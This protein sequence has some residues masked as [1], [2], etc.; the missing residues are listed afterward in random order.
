MRIARSALLALTGA[1]VWISL[2]TVAVVD[3]STTR[4]GALPPVWLLI[5]LTTAGAGAGAMWR[6]PMSTLAPLALTALLWLPWLPFPVP[7]AFLIWSGPAEWLLWTV[8]IGGVAAAL[9]SPRLPSPVSSW[10]MQ[11]RRAVVLTIVLGTLAALAAARHLE[12]RI[13]AGDEPHYLIITQSVLLDGDLQIENNH[14]RGDYQPYS[15]DLLRPDFLRRGVNGQIYS[16]HAPGLPVL[17]APAFAIGGYHGVVIFIAL[18]VALGGALA[19]HAA[20]MISGSSAAAWMAWVAVFFSSPVFFHAF[21]VYPDGAGAAL[22]MAAVWLLVRLEVNPRSVSPLVLAMVG[23][24]LAILPWLHSRF[25]IVA[26]GLG[27]ALLLRIVTRTKRWQNATAFLVVPIVFAIAWFGFFY[28]VYGT[29]SPTAPYGSVTQNRLAT[30]KPGLPG[31]IFDQQFGLVTNA[32]IFAVALLGLVMLARHHRR[33][34]IEL[35]LVCVPYVLAVASFAMWWAGHSA[36]ARF[37]LILLLPATLPIAWLFV[38]AP[39]WGRAVIGAAAIVGGF[40]VVLRTL[41]DAG[42]LLYN[43]RDGYDLLLDWLSPTVNLPLA[44]P[45]FHRDVVPAAVSDSLIW[46][47]AMVVAFAAIWAAAKWTTQSRG[48]QWATTS[49]IVCFTVMIAVTLVWMRHGAR[50]ITPETSELAFLQQWDPAW[51]PIELQLVPFARLTRED[52]LARIRLESPGRGPNP[53]PNRPLLSVPLVPAGEYE[54]VV[55]GAARPAGMLDVSVGRSPQTVEQFDLTNRSPGATGIVLRLPVL[56][57]S[58]TIRGDATASRAVGHIALRP[59]SVRPPAERISGT[60]ARRAA[61]YG[62]RRVFFLDEYPYMEIPGFWT[63]GLDPTTVVIDPDDARSDAMLVRAGA[64]ATQVRL[65]AGK[66]TVKYDL[67]PGQLQTVE[68]PRPPAAAPVEIETSARF[69]PSDF[70]KTSSDLRELGVW[71]EFPR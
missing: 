52:V 4:I 26:A 67:G 59:L 23:T 29:F 68:L 30:L 20:W 15:A 38:H 46:T 45:S 51:N 39:V 19:W 1:S 71:I 7:A 49:A 65:S 57:H 9:M 70:D 54:L 16:I 60:Y 5:A 13:P 50:A 12:H 55:S 25:A 32:P 34:V 27:V 2:G 31:L 44:F 53:G 40:F 37:L 11:P 8:A 42:I 61:R 33:V 64:V 35:S 3:P 28:V 66:W 48:M 63:H 21:T 36:P 6:T 18:L 17:V 43:G 24:S 56:V 22:A 14:T 69:K 10:V 47:L 41:V 62:S 58:I